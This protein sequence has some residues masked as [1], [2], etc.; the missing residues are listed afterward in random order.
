MTTPDLPDPPTRVPERFWPQ[1]ALPPYRY[2]PLGVHPHPT[3]DEGGHMRT[4]LPEP[5]T[6][7]SELAWMTNRWWLLGVDLY[8]RWYFWEAQETWEPLWRKLDRRGPEAMFLQALMMCCGA[9][10]KLHCKETKGV[11][12]FWD[13]ADE[14]FAA[15]SR[16][17]AELWGLKTKKTYKTWQKYFKPLIKKGEMPPLDKS[18]P[19]IKLPM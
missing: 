9:L 15:T 1:E 16:A 8:N 14:R 19:V 3:M 7:P 18:V 13:G 6:M 4:K 17:C 12:A 10:L 11:H 5:D 2:V